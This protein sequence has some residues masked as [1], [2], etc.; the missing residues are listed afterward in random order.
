MQAQ[1]AV[2]RGG[3]RRR[4]SSCTA[5]LAQ[6]RRR[7]RGL[8]EYH[9]VGPAPG[10][11]QR[12]VVREQARRARPRGRRSRP[13]AARSARGR[14][15]SRAWPKKP[16]PTSRRAPRRVRPSRARRCGAARRRRRPGAA[17]P[18]CA[19]PPRR[20]AARRR[21]SSSR[22]S[23]DVRRIVEHAAILA[24]RLGCCRDPRT[25]HGARV[26]LQ[27]LR[28]RRPPRRQRRP[29]RRRRPAGADHRRDR[30]ARSR[31]PRP[32]HAPSPRPRRAPR[33]DARALPRAPVLAHP[34][35]EAACPAAPTRRS[36][37]ATS[38][39][40]ATSASKPCTRPA[41]PTGCSFVVDGDESSPA[42][43]SSGPVVA[44]AGRLRRAS[45]TCELDHR[46]PAPS[47]IP[48]ACSIPVTSAAPRWRGNGRRTR[49]CGS[50]AGST[51]RARS[52]HGARRARDAD[53]LGRRLRRR[54]Q[55]L[56]ALG[57]RSRRHRPG[58]PGRAGLSV[59]GGRHAAG[60][61]RGGARARCGGQPRRRRVCL[62]D[63]AAA[64]ERA[65][66]SKSAWSAARTRGR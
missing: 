28:R 5:S 41:T 18:G 52:L 56:G 9:E 31:D 58:Q 44:C 37:M 49:S 14:R 43:R 4:R 30:A 33:G 20:S 12:V 66:G 11:E 55:G 7:R 24:A 22:S 17:R 27:L 13:R 53:P 65:R 50:G 26:A 46:T 36:A 60:G 21:S 1:R 45:R 40:A 62:V 10:L 23:C 39:R 63:A 59:A 35:E 8:G 19:G 2:V 25:R 47:S 38:S 48:R 16:T 32:R 42:T 34:L 6:A 3:P 57:R 61:R 51:A 15:P 64:R 29:H 54:L